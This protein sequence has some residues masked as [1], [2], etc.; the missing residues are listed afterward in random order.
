M[1]FELAV[2]SRK[3]AFE[4]SIEFPASLANFGI[5]EN[6]APEVLDESIRLV[7]A[8]RFQVVAAMDSGS[9]RRSK[10]RLW[11]AGMRRPTSAVDPTQACRF[12][13]AADRSQYATE[14]IGHLP[15]SELRAAASSVSCGR[16]VTA[17]IKSPK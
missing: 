9:R 15:S 4:F 12:S 11:S 7:S 6:F 5:R 17:G 2:R 1:G 16:K 14:L 13:R 8:V 3:F 10:L